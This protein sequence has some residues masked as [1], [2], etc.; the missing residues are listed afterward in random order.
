MNPNVSGVGATPPEEPSSKQCGKLVGWW[1]SMKVKV[2]AFFSGKR[3]DSAEMGE[4]V[5]ERV[6]GGRL[7]AEALRWFGPETL[8]IAFSSLHYEP[9]M[10]HWVHETKQPKALDVTAIALRVMFHARQEEV[11]RAALI[12]DRIKP[13]DSQ[14]LAYYITHLSPAEIVLI[15]EKAPIDVLD[16]MIQFIPIK[17]K[18]HAK[19]VRLIEIFNERFEALQNELSTLRTVQDYHVAFTKLNELSLPMLESVI[20]E[21]NIDTVLKLFYNAPKSLEGDEVQVF[22][23]CL[24]KLYGRFSEQEVTKRL[25]AQRHEAEIRA[26]YSSGRVAI[27][28]V[29]QRDEILK[30][31]HYYY[32]Q[33]QKTK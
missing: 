26:I 16:K 24:K 1:D 28:T 3:F 2:E 17:D 20:G 12:P 27:A 4:L 14:R 29:T 11:K 32:R 23:K 13:H 18:E 8:K 31:H 6:R 15:G 22:L 25:E 21:L 33:D 19:V 10:R 30:G 7:T 5:A 9:R